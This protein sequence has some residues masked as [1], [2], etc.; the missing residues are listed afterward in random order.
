MCGCAGGETAAG[1]RRE[2]EA[3]RDA[4]VANYAAKR[5]A[6]VAELLPKVR[7]SSLYICLTCTIA[8]H[9]HAI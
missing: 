7:G 5:D 1:A 2:L 6:V 3:K 8:Q 4:L 9:D